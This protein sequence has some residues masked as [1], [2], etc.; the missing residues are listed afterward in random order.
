MAYIDKA[1]FTGYTTTVIDDAEFTVLA[2]RASD[3]ID[4]LTMQR[5]GGDAGFALL[6]VATQEAIKKATA[7][8]VETLYLQGGIEALT[9][10]NDIV[11][12]SIGKFSYASKGSGQTVNGMPVSPL[13]SG[14][15]LMTGLMHRRIEVVCDAPYT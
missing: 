6:L 7:A 13:I 5:I 9:G 3:I 15:L 4:I 11:S 12:G 2:N 1:F 10:G 8:E 14:Y